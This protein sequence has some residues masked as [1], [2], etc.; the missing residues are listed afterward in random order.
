VGGELQSLIHRG[1]TLSAE[2]GVCAS[3]S[4]GSAEGDDDG[5]ASEDELISDDELLALYRCAAPVS[6][7]L[8][9]HA[10]PPPI[11]ANTQFLDTELTQAPTQSPSSPPVT[12][13]PTQP[14]TTSLPSASPTFR[15]TYIWEHLDDWMH[16]PT[17][18]PTVAQ[19]EIPI[20]QLIALCT[21]TTEM[22]SAQESVVMYKSA[23]IALF[24]LLM[25][26][27]IVHVRI[28]STAAL[29]SSA[30]EDSANDV[31]VIDFENGP[32]RTVAH[33][34]QQ[35]QQRAQV[36]HGQV[37]N[38]IPGHPQQRTDNNSNSL[39]N[40]S[41]VTSQPKAPT[42][43][44]A[45]MQKQP[46]SEKDWREKLRS[47]SLNDD[48]D[49]DHNAVPAVSTTSSS[50][51]SSSKGSSISKKGKDKRSSKHS[52]NEA[53]AIEMSTAPASKQASSSSSS[54]KGDYVP[55]KGNDSDNEEAEV[56][57]NPFTRT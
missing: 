38:P 39:F 36:M 17:Y 41:A 13:K 29:A 49:S 25:V 37:H 27:L 22:M 45:G 53:C 34:Q 15:P 30:R 46:V 6:T 28:C 44:S 31:T 32:P 47:F 50:S 18:Q 3:P 51:K 11:F 7:V 35:Q 26:S 19:S 42:L 2:T 54:K 48:S 16:I 9:V 24:V 52:K 23:A 14:P 5:S 55:V 33:A 12:P 21:N 1:V 8:C 43:T 4:S 56:E 20:E 10:M 57:I 40:L